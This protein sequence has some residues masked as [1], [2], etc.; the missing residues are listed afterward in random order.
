[1]ADYEQMSKVKLAKIY[2]STHNHRGVDDETSPLRPEY[3]YVP[4]FEPGSPEASAYL[5]ENG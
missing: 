3:V 5:E 2:Q 1:M 4:R